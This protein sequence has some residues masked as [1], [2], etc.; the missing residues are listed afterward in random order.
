MSLTPVTVIGGYLGAGKTTLI[1][2]C[3]K[4]RGERRIA[5]LVND[6]GDINI[7][8]ALIES[9]TDTVLNLAGGCVCCTIGSDFMEALFGLAALSADG[10]P[11]FDHVLVE[12]SGV[13]LPRPLAQ[14]IGLCPDFRVESILV[15]AD[16]CETVARLRDPYMADTVRQQL[17]QADWILLTKSGEPG[18]SPPEVLRKLMSAV[19]VLA[20]SQEQYR[21]D[22]LLGQGQARGVR[23]AGRPTAWP[24]KIGPL[25]PSAATAFDS[26]SVRLE[27]PLDLERLTACLRQWAGAR[28]GLV[29]AKGFVRAQSGPQDPQLLQLVGARLRLGPAERPGPDALVLIG[30]KG[31]FAAGHPGMIEFSSCLEM[32]R[33][34]ATSPEP[35]S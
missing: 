17:D 10:A 14:S 33:P 21:C 4:T 26:L 19:P 18:A 20:L 28:P 35:P 23:S 16:A 13:A 31:A 34:D 15:L 7:D 27:A 1:N 2:A 8:A 3:L 12:T 5:V 30:L 22:W 11:R 6:F 25:N 32:H 24:G 9:Q 29:R